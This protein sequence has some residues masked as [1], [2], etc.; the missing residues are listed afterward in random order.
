MGLHD[1]TVLEC[2]QVCGEMDYEFFKRITANSNQ[3]SRLN[4]NDLGYFRGS[5]W[6]KITVQEMICFHGVL[7]K[8]SVDNRELGGHK[9]YFTDRI[10]VNLS[11][12]YSV[13]MIGLPAWA[14]KV[15]S[16]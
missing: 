7:F 12:T 1:E 9:L 11:R 15:M 13:E 5:H 14:L 2:I 10:S 4:M 6:T 3:Y 8:M 16:L